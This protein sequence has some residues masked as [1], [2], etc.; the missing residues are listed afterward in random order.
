[1]RGGR[2]STS[3]AVIRDD[4]SAA[5]STTFVLDAIRR[6]SYCG[7]VPHHARA[8]ITPLSHIG[9]AL[10]LLRIRKGLTQDEVGTLA[11]LDRS[12]VGGV[13]RGVRNLSVLALHRLLA[14][15]GG[16]GG[17]FAALLETQQDRS[18]PAD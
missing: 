12:Y 8:P 16:T 1:M 18:D 5:P 3:H 13:E 7:H 6:D 14:A 11:D 2:D 17:E 15:V 10:R 4:E 9:K